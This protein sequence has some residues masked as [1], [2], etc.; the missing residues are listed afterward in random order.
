MDN[1][2][3]F[4]IYTLLEDYKICFDK[5]FSFKQLQNYTCQTVCFSLQG[6]TQIT[7]LLPE[8]KPSHAFHVM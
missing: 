2:E 3:V 8:R 6:K 7:F 4:Q 5:W 1:K